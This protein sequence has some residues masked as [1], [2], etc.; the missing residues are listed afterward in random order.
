[1]LNIYFLYTKS[2]HSFDF[3]RYKHSYNLFL[4]C[5]F[6]CIVVLALKMTNFTCWNIGQHVTILTFV[7]MEI[8]VS[9]EIKMQDMFNIW[10]ST[11]INII[12]ALQGNMYRQHYKIIAL[13]ISRKKADHR[14]QYGVKL[15]QVCFNS[16]KIPLKGKENSNVLPHFLQDLLKLYRLLKTQEMK[17]HD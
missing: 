5:C 15:S 11:M 1:M 3:K 2:P 7:V 13:F 10:S 4:S 17:T 8:A 9:D 12:M 6:P 16:H 14:T